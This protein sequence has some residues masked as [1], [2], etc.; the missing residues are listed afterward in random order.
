VT[1]RGDAVDLLLA[2]LRRVRVDDTD[3]ALSGDAAVWQTWLD[4]TPL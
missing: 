4:H 2:L 1:L 3:I